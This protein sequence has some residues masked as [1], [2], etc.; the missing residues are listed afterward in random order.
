MG[1]LCANQTNTQEYSSA[2]IEPAEP[3]TEPPPNPEDVTKIKKRRNVT[4]ADSIE[5]RV[6]S[7]AKQFYKCSKV[8]N[9]K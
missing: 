5:Q 3:A 4:F 7:S 8:G 1:N 6:P 2:N 9:S